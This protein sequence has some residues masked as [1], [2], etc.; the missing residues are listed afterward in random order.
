MGL[1]SNGT[2]M[3]WDDIVKYVDMIKSQGIRQFISIYRRL[4]TRQNDMLKWGDE[5]WLLWSGY[6]YLD[7]FCSI[8]MPLS[9]SNI[10]LQTYYV[11][12]YMD[13]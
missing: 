8:L 2:P 5:V 11:Y 12:T 1:L 9:F 13:Y 3:V 10:S 4:L 7:D 6:A